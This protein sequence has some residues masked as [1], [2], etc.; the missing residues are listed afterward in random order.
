M[1][2]NESQMTPR[3]HAEHIAELMRQA[4]KECRADIGRIDDPKAQ[5]LFETLAE[6]LQGGIKALEDYVGQK[7]PVWKARAR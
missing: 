7:E 5:A 2:A 6:V 4:E 1:A 3:Q